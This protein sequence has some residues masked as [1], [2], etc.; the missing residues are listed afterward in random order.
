MVHTAISLC[1][2]CQYTGRKLTYCKEKH[3]RFC[4][5]NTET[6]NEVNADKI[7][8]MIISR[9]Q[10]AGRSCNIKIDY[11]SFKSVEAFKYLGTT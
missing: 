8:Y 9:Y 11:M 4:S 10:N 7:N 5:Y 3:G 2:W 6:G 1:W